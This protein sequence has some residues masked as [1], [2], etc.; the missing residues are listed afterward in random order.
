M[1]ASV[2]PACF[3]VDFRAAVFGELSLNDC[4]LRPEVRWEHAYNNN[5]YDSGTRHSQFRFAADVV[6]FY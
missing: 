3:L 1:V 2:M 5:A 4:A 6:R